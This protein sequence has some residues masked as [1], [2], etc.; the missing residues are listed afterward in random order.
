MAGLRE[1]LFGNTAKGLD[2]TRMAMT[3]S[4]GRDIYYG[5]GLASAY[6][7]NAKATQR[8]VEGF[9]KGFAED[10]DVQFNYLPTLRA[11]LALMHSNP[12]Q[13]LDDLELAAPYELEIG[14]ASCRERVWIE[15]F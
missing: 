1:D 11:K 12:L 10:T 14:R 5:F 9:E 7:K 3:P 13:A 15:V 8:F 2:Q 6:A 4:S